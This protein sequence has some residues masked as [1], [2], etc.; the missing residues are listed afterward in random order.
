MTTN[1]LTG[2]SLSDQLDALTTFPTLQ[3][4]RAIEELTSIPPLEFEAALEEATTFPSAEL[5]A[6]LEEA[7]SFPT[8]QVKTAMEELTTFPTL[9]LATSTIQMIGYNQA[10]LPLYPSPI[11]NPTQKQT[12]L[13]TPRPYPLPPVSSQIANFYD[14]TLLERAVTICEEKFPTLDPVKIG[15]AGVHVIVFFGM[16]IYGLEIT[17]V[18]KILGLVQV[19]ALVV[20]AMRDS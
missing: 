17:P 5:E 11:H 3:V 15:L 13:P 8:T 2:P 7:A 20:L 4:D 10:S 6:A 1:A 9:E 14:G 12:T 19:I 18:Q 16:T